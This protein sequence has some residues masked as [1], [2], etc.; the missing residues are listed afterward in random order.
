MITLI[1]D[2]EPMALNQQQKE[3]ILKFLATSAQKNNLVK[4]VTKKE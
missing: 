4:E 1:Y 3:M 2:G